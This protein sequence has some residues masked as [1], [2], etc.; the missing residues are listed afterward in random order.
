MVIPGEGFTSEELFRYAGRAR[1]AHRGSEK[2]EVVMGGKWKAEM[3]PSPR[4]FGQVTLDWRDAQRHASSLN[5]SQKKG[6]RCVYVLYAVMTRLRWRDGRREG[7]LGGLNVWCGWGVITGRRAEGWEPNGYFILSIGVCKWKC[8]SGRKTN[9][10]DRRDATSLAECL[11]NCHCLLWVL[12][13]FLWLLLGFFVCCYFLIVFSSRH[14]SLWLRVWWWTLSQGNK[15]IDP[16]QESMFSSVTYKSG[17]VWKVIFELK[18]PNSVSKVKVNK[19]GRVS[20]SIV[21]FKSTYSVLLIPTFA[22]NDRITLI[23][24][25]P[26]GNNRKQLVSLQLSK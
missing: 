2:Q 4:W 24:K 1:E 7:G 13:F 10:S 6:M 21:V 26:N 22:F 17:S 8:Q 12:I 19:R 9:E 3:C 14:G 11:I 23:L 18:F 20:P 5:S 16:R 15:G 25:F